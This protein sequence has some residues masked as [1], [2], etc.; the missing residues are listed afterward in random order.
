M[1]ADQPLTGVLDTSVVIHHADLPSDIEGRFAI[2]VMTIAELHKGAVMARSV[3]IRA[4][5][6]ARLAM[7]EQLFEALPVD[8]RVA[9]KFGEVAAATR[10]LERRPHVV[11]GL[12]AATAM[13]HDV[14][15]YTFDADFHLISGLRVVKL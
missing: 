12:I 3:R 6:I 2:S 10:R 7:A 14:P 5:R 13:V 1:A 4:Q 9:V 8:R 15:V 11:D